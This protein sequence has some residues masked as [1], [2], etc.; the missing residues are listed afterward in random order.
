MEEQRRGRPSIPRHETDRHDAGFDVAILGDGPA[1]SVAALSLAESGARVMLLGARHAA[2]AAARTGQCLPA[3]GST[4]MRALGLIDAFSAGPHLPI[5]ANRAAWS[6]DRIEAMDLIRG[7][8][9]HAWLLDRPAFDALLRDAAKAKA[10]AHCTAR[11]RVQAHAS[12]RGWRFDLYSTS[13][14]RRIIEASF[15]M[16]A[17]GRASVLALR[18]GARR[19]A[20]DRLVAV[21]ARFASPDDSDVDRTTLIEAEEQ[22]WWYTCRLG[23]GHRVVIY[24][25]D[26][27][28]LPRAHAHRAA[29]ISDRLDKTRHLKPLLAAHGYVRLELLE[30]VLANS[31]RLDRPAGARWIAAG[32]A[33]GSYDP[34]SGHGLIAAL[35]SG[36]HAAAALVSSARGETGAMRGF[37]DLAAERYRHYQRELEANYAAQPRWSS[38]P[39]WA[40]RRSGGA[41]SGRI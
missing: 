31:A 3:Q 27:D 24:F 21:V 33:A 29:L 10:V 36:R 11:G 25:T 5:L 37:L 6:S 28:L 41:G 39:F 15:A 8:H 40:R 38:S 23:S 16:D 17:S 20:H 35:D 9:G 22:G 19:C 1:G 30:V 2:A 34:L 26:G 7:A 14:L 18:N 32:D 12:A 13:G 4:W